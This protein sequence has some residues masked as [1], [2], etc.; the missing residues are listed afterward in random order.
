MAAN[1]QLTSTS[2]LSLEMQTYYDRQLLENM[3]PKLVHY[4]FGQKRR[5]PKHNSKTIEFRKFTPFAADTTPLTEGTVPDGQVLA[6]TEVT[7]TVAQYGDYVAISDMLDLTAIDPIISESI[8]LC[9]DQAALS[10]DTIIR[11]VIHL[12]TNKIV[13]NSKT[14]RWRLL[15]GDK[16]TTTEVRKAV[17]TLKKAKA[18]PFNRNGKMVYIAIVGP[19]TTFDLQA[20]TLWQDV[21]KYS[22]KEQIFSGEIGRIFGVVFVE[23]TEDKKFAAA[24]LITASASLTC[25]AGGYVTATKVMTVAEAISAAEA[26]ALVG[27]KILITNTDSG[28]ASEQDTI[29]SATEGTAGTAT[30]T[31]TTGL[32][33]TNTKYNSQPVYPGEAGAAGIEVASTLFLGQNAYGVVDIE[34]GSKPESLVK[35]A[36]SAGT[37]DPLNQIS[38][39]GWKLPAFCAVILQQLFMVRVEHG[40][41]A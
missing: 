3:K 38:T 21:S 36:G 7:A 30:I 25:T 6:L 1:T 19:D 5:L 4:E 11:D 39:V 24:N 18:Q 13:G 10:A 27:R 37:S 14:Y 35:P 23:T 17:R 16:L 20:D 26:L 41:S 40:Y 31:L 28:A 9:S 15:A 29:A 33:A 32:A 22:D 12:G 34:N 2:A 8:D